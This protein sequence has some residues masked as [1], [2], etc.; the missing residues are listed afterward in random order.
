MIHQNATFLLKAFLQTDICFKKNILFTIYTCLS[1]FSTPFQTTN[2]SVYRY[3]GMII[4]N[5][6]AI[7]MKHQ[8]ED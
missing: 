7:Y 6:G 4:R 3:G 8:L 5:N 2:I 1:K